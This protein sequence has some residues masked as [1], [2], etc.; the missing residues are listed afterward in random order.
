MSGWITQLFTLIACRRDD[1]IVMHNDR[2]DRDFPFVKGNS[3]LI[4]GGSHPRSVRL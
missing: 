2:A 4:Q 3:R 1:A